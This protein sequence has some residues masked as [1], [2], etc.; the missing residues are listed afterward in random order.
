MM[1]MIVRVNRLRVISDSVMVSDMCGFVVVICFKLILSLRL[2]IE[3]IVRMLF[4]LWVGLI[5]DLGM[6]FIDWVVVS[7]RNVRMNLGSSG[8]F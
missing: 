7:V 6:K 1:W 5:V 3:M 8:M 2:V 4:S